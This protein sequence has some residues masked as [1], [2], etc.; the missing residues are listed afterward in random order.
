MIQLFYRLFEINS[1]I[2]RAYLDQSLTNL[3]TSSPW[4]ERP[5]IIPCSQY[6]AAVHKLM[7]KWE[8]RLFSTNTPHPHV[9][10]W[11]TGPEPGAPD[12]NYHTR[13]KA[14]IRT[15]ISAMVLLG[16]G[17]LLADCSGRTLVR[18][19]RSTRSRRDTAILF[20]RPFIFWSPFLSGREPVNL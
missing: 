15:T 17:R 9:F 14:N 20:R 10:F 5:L 8:S 13:A 19:D 4:C 12:S 7:V 11:G 3:S 16:R 2:P 1:L 6:V 18:C